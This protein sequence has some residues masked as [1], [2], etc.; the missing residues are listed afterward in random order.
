MKTIKAGLAVTCA[1]LI[2]IGCTTPREIIQFYE[3]QCREYG[4]KPNTDAMAQCV[5][6]LDKK[7]P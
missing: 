1:A 4:F 3:Q 2:L 5:Q 7:S 6:R